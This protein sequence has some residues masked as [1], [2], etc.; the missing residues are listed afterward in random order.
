MQKANIKAAPA[1]IKAKDRNA[2]RII[3]LPA[4]KM[5]WSG[6]CPSSQSKDDET[7]RRFEQWFPAQDELLRREHIYSRDFL[8]HDTQAQGFAWG[9]TVTEIPE[10]TGGWEVMDFPG[11]LFAVVNYNCEKGDR[12]PIDAYYGIEKWVEKSGCF[13]MDEGAGRHIMWHMFNP[14]AA[15]EAMGYGQCDQYVP[16]RIKEATK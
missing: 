1:T 11:G 16:I 14:N 12:G 15:Y 5:V 6:I 2:V 4:S 13:V 8:W 10:D 7:I 3:E 9:L